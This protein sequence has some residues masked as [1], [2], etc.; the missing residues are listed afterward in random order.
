MNKENQTK[1]KYIAIHHPPSNGQIR[2]IRISIE[3]ME[4]LVNNPK[5]IEEK[6]K[7]EDKIFYDFNLANKEAIRLNCG[8]EEKV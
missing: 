5:L 1:E 4:S 8:L 3:E 7:V 6:I 2:V